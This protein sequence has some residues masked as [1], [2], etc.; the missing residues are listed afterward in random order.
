MRSAFNETLLQLAKE[1]PRIFMILADIG[2]GEIEPF[3]ERFPDRFFNVGV[4]EQN[5]TGVACGVAMEGELYLSKENLLW[6]NEI[7][8]SWKTKIFLRC[9]GLIKSFTLIAP[10]QI[11]KVHSSFNALS[12][13]LTLQVS[14]DF[15]EDLE[16]E[17][18][19]WGKVP[20]ITKLPPLRGEVIFNTYIDTQ[21]GR[22]LTLVFGYRSPD[23]EFVDIHSEEV[24]LPQSH[25][26]LRIISTGIELATLKLF[27]VIE[28]PSILL[29]LLHELIKSYSSLIL[30]C[31]IDYREE[32]IHIL[33][34]SSK[35][36]LLNEADALLICL[37]WHKG[38][39]LSKKLHKITNLSRD[40]SILLSDGEPERPYPDKTV[41]LSC[42]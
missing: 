14:G 27:L 21:L 3:A 24:V 22:E 4:A 6:F 7:S 20:T 33:S 1:N 36:H 19:I 15:P 38:I 9:D 41:M 34:S 11:Y 17:V 39:G 13:Q 23:D 40:F 35:V 2:Y 30:E 16:G 42:V 8:T 37:P 29:D 26:D 32:L 5:M 25:T 28:N 31:P 10:P 18:H 12:R